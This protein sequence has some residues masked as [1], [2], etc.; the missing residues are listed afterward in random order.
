[1]KF[2]LQEL[3]KHQATDNQINF[4]TDCSSFLT[5]DMD[6]LVGLSL[7]Q[8][9]GI[10]HVHEVDNRY[11]FDL[12]IKC[13]CTMLCAITLKEISVPLDFETTLE[14]ASK[15]ED[16]HTFPIDGTTID[17][18]PYIFAEIVVEKPM[19]VISPDLPNDFSEDIV[20]LDPEEKLKDNPFSK[21]RN[22]L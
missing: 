20:T 21:L 11:V 5:P 22:K 4:V 8:V 6:D 9:S 17:L 12:K 19:K 2:S 7:V 16:D 1:M 15:V 3:R 14:F 13:V 10:Y 18:D